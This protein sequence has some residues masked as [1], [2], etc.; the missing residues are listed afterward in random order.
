MEP[1]VNTLSVR[2]GSCISSPAV[3]PLMC[4]RKW[5]R[6]LTLTRLFLKRIAVCVFGILLLTPLLWAQQSGSATSSIP[7][8]PLHNSAPTHAVPDPLGTLPPKIPDIAERDESCLLWTVAEVPASTISAVALQVPGKARGEYKKGCSDSRSKKLGDAENHL[9]KAVEEYP[10]YAAAWVLLGQVL[11]AGNRV[12]EA[13]GA[14]SQA[15]IVDPG[16]EQAYLCLADAAGQLHEWKETLDQAERALA[17]DPRR[18]AYGCFYTSMA[19]FYLGHL[20][21]AEKA[22]LEAI[23]ADHFH[24]VPQVHLLLAHIY[25][26][27]N[28]LP[29][30]AAQLRAYLKIVPHAPNS[31]GVKKTLADIESNVAN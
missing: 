1:P 15:S 12:E 9:R 2:I 22:A 16:Y 14:C 21:E 25:R 23:D 3:C 17:L 26:M 19:H 28:D 4:C 8:W 31:V 24:R 29:D 30:A 13:R 27:K 7:G 10:Q 18:N 6:S 5:Y 11:E 20:L